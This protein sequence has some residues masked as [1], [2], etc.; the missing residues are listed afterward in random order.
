M[1]H[2]RE[3]DEVDVA[4]EV[5]ARLALVRAEHVV[6]LPAGRALGRPRPEHAADR[7]LPERHDLARL[8]RPLDHLQRPPVDEAE[9]DERLYVQVHEH[10]LHELQGHVLQVAEGGGRPVPLWPRRLGARLW[11]VLVEN[12]GGD[13]IV[14]SEQGIGLVAMTIVSHDV[15]RICV[16]CIYQVF[17]QR[18]PKSLQRMLEYVTVIEVGPKWHQEQKVRGATRFICGIP[19]S[20]LLAVTPP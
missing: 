7:P 13:I 1:A 20:E 18:M 4:P 9:V 16:A 17:S 14:T 3:G 10:L 5:P 11:Q 2:P 12:I 15:M 19:T 6:K 8:V